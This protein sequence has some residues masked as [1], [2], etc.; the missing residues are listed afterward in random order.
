MGKIVFWLL[1]LQLSLLS[2]VQDN[3]TEVNIS[4]NNNSYLNDT[5]ENNN[6]SNKKKSFFN[7]NIVDSFFA[8]TFGL[9]TCFLSSSTDD[10][11]TYGNKDSF[12]RVLLGENIGLSWI[13]NNAKVS[14]YDK[15][16]YEHEVGLY[17]SKEMSDTKNYD[18]LKASKSVPYLQLSQSSRGVYKINRNMFFSLGVGFYYGKGISKEFRRDSFNLFYISSYRINNIELELIYKCRLIDWDSLFIHGITMGEYTDIAYTTNQ[19][20]KLN[21]KMRF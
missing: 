10:Y 19:V 12:N 18:D 2:A 13:F 14:K 21:L 7:N 17:Y 8:V 16:F 11:E 20:L 5:Q 3:S 4:N 15:W 6:S 1:I 9:N